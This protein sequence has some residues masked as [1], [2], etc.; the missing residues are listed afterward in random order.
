MQVDQHN[1]VEEIKRRCE[2]ISKRI[3]TK[4]I[5][6]RSIMDSASSPKEAVK[7]LDAKQLPYL[8]SV[9]IKQSAERQKPS[10]VSRRLDESEQREAWA[11][12]L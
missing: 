1:S 11:E 2:Q 9:E 4:Q 10:C 3:V 5:S 6:N 7:E 8:K 12:L